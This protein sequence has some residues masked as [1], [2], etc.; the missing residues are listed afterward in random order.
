LE[1]ARRTHGGRHADDC[2]RGRSQR[3]PAGH[4]SRRV[5]SRDGPARNA[6]QSGRILLTGSNYKYTKIGITLTQSWYG[7]TNGSYPPYGHGAHHT[8]AHIHVAV[9]DPTTNLIR[10]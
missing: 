9:N 1:V 3:C 4:R 2:K 7:T 8:T 6:V 10:Y 5:A